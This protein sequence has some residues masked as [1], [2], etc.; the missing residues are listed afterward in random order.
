MTA[1]TPDTHVDPTPAEQEIRA[2]FEE[3]GISLETASETEEE[4]VARLVSQVESG[5]SSLDSFRRSLEPFRTT[6]SP[7]EQDILDLFEDRNIAAPD[8]DR[9]KRLAEEVRGGRSLDEIGTSLDSFS[10]AGDRDFQ[11]GGDEDTAL[12][13]LMGDDM[14]WNQDPDTG[15]WYVIYGMPES[16]RFL[17]FEAS[18]E[19]MDALFGQGKRPGKGKGFTFDKLMRQSENTFSGNIGEMSGTGTFEDEVRR[20]KTLALDN[21]L[22]P[23]WAD[24]DKGIMD[25]LYIAQAEFKTTDWLIEQIAKT[26]SFKK[27]FV[28]IDRLKTDGNLTTR[29]SIAGYLEYEAGVIAAV[30][31]IDGNVGAITPD[32]IG[33]LLSRNLSVSTVTTATVKFKRMKDYEPA[34]E[35]FNRILVDQGKAPITSLQDMFDFV[36][37]TA[38]DT[39]YDIWEA[40]SI[41]EAAADAG[42][43][44]VFNAEDAMAFALQTD[45]FVSLSDAMG[46]FQSA[47]QQILQFRTEIDLG[48]FD[49]DQEDLIDLSLGVAPRSGMDTV[50]LQANMSRAVLAGQ[51]SQRTR[52]K[53]FI[54]FSD[55]G[56]AQRASL[57]G[58]RTT[59]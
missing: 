36:S 10:T 57:K 18:D 9:L 11:I 19:Q 26:D 51:A 34:I 47:A 28:G 23:S 3:L 48:R 15:S 44:G 33:G 38:D 45:G 42:L 22:L 39:V 29:E 41:S 7:A 53:P 1:Q 20:V 35:A 43:G 6:T 16:D 58:L 46:A 49:L 21:G 25:L 54:G 27:R 13:I 30:R 24:G 5:E 37:G 2:L 56:T 4:R 40:S 32:V 14:K 12:T 31:S 50:E 52:A 59:Q 17:V 55:S 8:A